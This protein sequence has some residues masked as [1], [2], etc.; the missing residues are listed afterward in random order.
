MITQNLSTDQNKGDKFVGIW[1]IMILSKHFLP[2]DKDCSRHMDH[3]PCKKAKIFVRPAGPQGV[4]S[5]TVFKHAHICSPNDLPSA[6]WVSSPFTSKGAGEKGKKKEPTICFKF[7]NKIKPSN[8]IHE[9]FSWVQ[10]LLGRVFFEVRTPSPQDK[11][12][13]SHAISTMNCFAPNMQGSFEQKLPFHFQHNR[14]LITM[15]V[16]FTFS[17]E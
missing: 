14:L 1:Y 12:N 17:R 15:S 7:K 2:S 8:L 9:L 5:R 4:C 13:G 16:K 10:I 6:P 3:V 11:N